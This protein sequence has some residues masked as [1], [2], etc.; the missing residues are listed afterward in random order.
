M[1]W[2]VSYLPH[3][4]KFHS[5]PFPVR[6]KIAVPDSEADL[7]EEVA[8]QRQGPG[9]LPFQLVAS[10]GFTEWM[11]RQRISLVVTTYQAGGMLLLGLKPNLEFSVYAAAFG[12]AMGLWADGQT[13]WLGAELAL[14]RFENTVASGV[15]QNGFD[16]I[17][18]PRSSH[19]TGDLDIHDL[20]VDG[21]GRPIFVNTRFSCLATVDEQYSFHPVWRPPFLSGLVPEDRCHLNGLAM[22]S[23]R[24]KYA[25]L[26]ARSDVAD[27]WRDRR[28]D[29]GLVMDVSSNEVIAEGLSMPHSPKI[30]DGRLWLLN[31]GTGYLGTIDRERGTFEPVTFLPGYA[32]GMAFCGDYVIVGLSRPRR[33]NAFKGLALDEH[34]S[35]KGAVPRCGLHV[36]E[37]ATGAVRHWLRI[38]GKIEELFDVAV[39]PGVVR[40]K[41]LSFRTPDL[42]HQYHFVDGGQV[43]MQPTRH[44]DD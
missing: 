33:D 16:R 26:V 17:Y 20:G 27:G 10:R 11:A 25:T 36:I 13:M 7:N 2:F 14:W 34:L 6:E 22:E 9:R 37:H 30:H 23:G 35:E 31:S 19:T 40:P 4:V 39:L 42:G 24:A 38:E 21:D 41:A 3:S 5:T 12:R 8:Y 18:F 44:R 1:G 28:H 15:V 29:G 43:N 32:R